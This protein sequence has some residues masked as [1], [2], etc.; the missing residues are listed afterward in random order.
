MS[1]LFF[2]WVDRINEWTAVLE[3]RCKG[4][5][6][7]YARIGGITHA[8]AA[9]KLRHRKK[10]AGENP[11]GIRKAQVNR[12]QRARGPVSAGDGPSSGTSRE[13]STLVRGAML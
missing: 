2:E 11:A 13:R 7:A 8:R 12:R 9:N 6:S 4:R 3:A 1:L 5:A 10:D